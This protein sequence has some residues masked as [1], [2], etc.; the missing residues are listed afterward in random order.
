M[1]RLALWESGKIWLRGNVRLLRA[2]AVGAG[3]ACALPALAGCSSDEIENDGSIRGTLM[4]YVATM[5]DGTSR[6]E[7]AIQVGGNE[8][9]ERM[10]VFAKAPPDAVSNAEIKVWGDASGR[11]IIVNRHELIQREK[12]S[13]I[14]KSQEAI[15]DG[16]PYPAR[17]FA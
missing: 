5:D 2:V 12:A 4:V 13:D 7:Y 8:N 10:L 11:E 6:T 9:D 15:I 1:P 17:T 3:L 14:G 16:T